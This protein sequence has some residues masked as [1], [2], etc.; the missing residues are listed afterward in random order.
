MTLTEKLITSLPES[1]WTEA[2]RRLKLTPALWALAETDN[3]TLDAFRVIGA[4]GN[5]NALS[6]A[7]RPAALGLAAYSARHAECDGNAEL[8]LLA[9]GHEIVG[10]AY[11]KLAA[12]EA[13]HPVEDA[14][15][16][17]LAARA[18]GQATTEWNTTA[19]DAH[20][21]PD[22]W[23]LIVQY[24]FGLLV[25][26]GEFVAALM[27]HSTATAA[28]AAHGLA[29]NFDAEAIETLLTDARL[30]LPARHWLVGIETF[31]SFGEGELAR[32]L[33]R[34]AA[35]A[36]A[37]TEA[38][39]LAA[40]IEHAALLAASETFDAAHQPLVAAWQ[41][42]RQARTS[43]AKQLGRVAMQAEQYHV[44]LAAYQDGLVDDAQNVELIT[45]MARAMLK[46]HAPEE[47]LAALENVRAA[48]RADLP[49][50]KLLLAQAHFARRNGGAAQAQLADFD[51]N[52]LPDEDT[53]IDA[54]KLF[55]ALGDNGQ[56]IAAMTRAA[57]V[58]QTNA[59][60]YLTA[61][62]W[63]AEAGDWPAAHAL[64][65]EASAFAPH[66][67][68]VREMAG[69]TL[70]ELQRPA[71]ALPHFQAAVAYEP[72]R[73]TAGLSLAR[74]AFGAHQVQLA[75]EAALN[76]LDQNPDPALAGEGHILM[77]EVLSAL[78]DEDGAFGHFSQAS[79]LMPAAPGPWR[80]MAR[81]HRT[82]GDADRAIAALEAGRQ[83]LKV[84]NSNEV[85]PLL[86][87]LADVYI[88]T[89]RRE[90]AIVALKEGC[91]IDSGS[92]DAHRKLGLL[93]RGTKQL[94]DAI[95]ALRHCLR[96]RPG[97]WR[98]LYELA[99]SL[100]ESGQYAEAWAAYQ[101]AVLARPEE[102]EPYFDLGRFT[103]EHHARGEVDALP[104]AAVSTLKE[105]VERNPENAEAH[106]LLAKALY[107]AGDANLALIS[108]QRAL[109]LQPTCTDWSLGL[110]QVCLQ[111]NRADIAVAALQQALQHAPHDPA[112]HFAFT[113][114]Y[115]QSQLWPN[116]A[117]S[118]EAALKL[119]PDNVKLQAM[120]AQAYGNLGQT[121]KA[122]QTWEKAIRL[123]PR[124]TEL[125]LYYARTLLALDRIEEARSVLGHALAIAPDSVDVHVAAGRAFME[126]G[127]N[128]IAYE[129]LTHA[130]QL[131]PR[132][133]E[134]HATF[135][136]AALRT[137]RFDAAHAAFIRASEL[138]PTRAEY[139]RDAGEALWRMDRLA[140]AV[141]LWQ[142]AVMVNPSDKITLA[143]LGMALL[144]MGQYG[145]SLAALEK[146]AEQ[147]PQDA[148]T[149]REAARAA[150]ELDELEKAELYL[151]RAITLMPGDPEA[152]YLLGR[153]CETLGDADKA[154][155]LYR[156]A[157]RLNPG[158]G[159][160]IAASAEVLVKLGN[161]SDATALMRSAVTVSPENAE[162]QQRAG[163]VFLNAQQPDAAAQAFTRWAELRPREAA[164]HLALAQA[165]T[166]LSER[167]EVEARAGVK[168]AG[169]SELHARL[170]T[171]LQ[172]AAALG[173]DPHVIRFWL[174]RA[175]A[176]F[177]QPKDAQQLLEAIIAQPDASVLTGPD[178]FRALGK[179]LR[180]SGDL[181]KAREALQAALSNDTQPEM[182]YMEMGLA[183]AAGNDHRG[184]AVALKRAVAANPQSA[185]GHFHLAEALHALGD[186]DDA[187][188]VLQRAIA[189][190][191]EV[192]AWH[193][194]LAKWL[195]DNAQALSHYQKAAQLEPANAEYNTDLARALMKDGEA[196]VAVQ[197]FSRATDMKGND[198]ELW[199][200]RGQAHFVLGDL[201]NA[202]DAF[203]QAI[204]LA[205]ENTTA[206]LGAA[207]V[208]AATGN[209]HAALN[210][211]ET[212]VRFSS[213]NPQALITLADVQAARGD[214]LAAE[215]H[216]HAAAAKSAD[217]APALLAL[218]KLHMAQGK[219]AQAI[220]VLSRAL[221]ASP[222]ADEILATLGE[223]KQSNNDYAGAVKAY[224]EA[225]RIAPRN[226]AHLL[227][228]GKACRVQGQLDQAIAHLMQA[229]DLAPHSDD[230]AR[231]IGLV[232][233]GRK[234][235][236]RALEMY[237]LAIQHAPRN[238][239]NHTRAGVALK[240]LKDYAGSVHALEKA[241]ALDPKNLEATRQLAAVTALNIIHGQAVHA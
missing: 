92:A 181:E 57:Q 68:A 54:A 231:E 152:R 126:L 186:A 44:A 162:V 96:L 5:P 94:S 56:A 168:G 135:G 85:A 142:R 29:A 188:L 129:T 58:A 114:A 124:D 193:Y 235:F 218:G 128:E 63:L 130:V 111:L 120:L 195:C 185:V 22:Q 157:A 105:A 17:A 91:A 132:A 149:A 147:N 203:A 166:Q 139:L 97:D 223:A 53:L 211:A 113:E 67:A 163:Q 42:V 37:A 191:P 200:E 38:T 165:L 11:A 183:L 156:Q 153:V 86:N 151:D 125:K 20:N 2:I 214:N 179:A 209:L 36:V 215:K 13:L 164:S 227:R 61:A 221:E 27:E 80:A 47:A 201:A 30:D 222:E 238:A 78:N 121:G 100:E 19:S 102:P 93:L 143:Q 167:R 107:L 75:H 88:E 216:Y 69:H 239:A 33:A 48:L 103:L 76:V 12:G 127:E 50:V 118:A 232:F 198:D 39:T 74:A 77:G 213:D 71:E 23:R 159:R 89:N 52:A 10:G 205:P 73:L 197:F 134:A 202:A 225:A 1:L 133:P 176:V 169:D 28:L 72:A 180:K 229:K 119:D 81:H 208:S 25:E 26:P 8:W 190:K 182:T 108:Y 95:H 40:T 60:H 109:H 136:E 62:Q 150:L 106:A 104:Q 210:Q 137:S 35:N 160:Y 187:A 15:P 65:I 6:E 3:S 70:L 24:L 141:A 189:L 138:D 41:A 154:L 172:Q 98:A 122:A 204:E 207:R 101:Q 220:E 79:T 84:A 161:L 4:N 46:L 18:R 131:A 55:R 21:N 217:P 237:E 184:A 66:E 83:A 145:D 90:D 219:S 178:Y 171:A 140:A 177:G 14:L 43:I 7:T 144:R 112:V 82:H 155:G 32:R 110:G 49:V 9:E 99:L 51:V 241:V 45:G 233:E 146:A 87:D 116:A 16:A 224:R 192:A 175:K 206:L 148:A 64:A 59:G 194:R 226:A 234:Q 158:E 117:R 228:L 123:D 196:G 199:T 173:A 174:G 31:K 236:D 170:T 34:H 115:V 212:A 240:Q 230:V